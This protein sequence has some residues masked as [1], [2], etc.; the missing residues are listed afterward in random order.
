[1]IKILPGLLQSLSQHDDPAIRFKYHA[2]LPQQM[3]SEPEHKILQEAIRTSPRVQ[4]LLSEDNT[5]GMIT[6][7]LYKKWNGAHWVLTIL[8]E[9]GYPQGD[10]A[11]LTLRDKVYEWLFS[12]KHQKSIQTIEGR[13][14]R[15][16]SQEANALYSSLTLGL[17]NDRTHLLARNLM[18][19]QWPDGGWNC[20]RHPE[21]HHSSFW[22]TITPLRALNLYAKTTGNGEASESVSRAAEIFLKRR[23]FR[24]QSTNQVMYPDFLLLHYPTYW[25]YDVLI[26]LKTIADAGLLGDPRCQEALDVL[27]SKQLPDGGF[28]AEGRFY[29]TTNPDLSGFSTVDWGG[30]SKKR[31]NPWITVNALDVLKRAGRLVF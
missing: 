21:A 28:P 30:V 8:A 11:L 23:M 22:E 2:L 12:E 27:E 4:A 29:Q 26:G 14:R 25:R 9:L 3:I 7:H 16:A 24:T 13:V 31:S 1:M 5:H 17:V 6:T 20:D 10:Q 18:R 19:W 15:C